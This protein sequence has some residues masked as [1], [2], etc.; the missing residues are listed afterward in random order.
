MRLFVVIPTTGRAEIVRRT[1]STLSGQSRSPD[2]ILVVA[3]SPADVSGL[4]ELSLPVE[5][6]FAPKGLCSQRNKA[7]ELL[8]QTADLIVFF[9]DDFIPAAS[10]LEEAQRLFEEI[11]ELVGA[12]GRMIADGANGPGISFEHGQELIA[13][14]EKGG[15][16]MESPHPMSAL[17]G[18]NMVFRCKSLDGLRFDEALPLYGWQED[19]DFTFRLGKRGRL[20]GSRVLAGVHMGA[21]VARSPGKRL[22]YS[23]IAN[24]VYLLK[25]GTTP[26]KLALKLMVQN[27]VANLIRSFSPEPHVDRRGRLHGNLLAFRD[28]LMGKL[29]PRR[30]LEFQ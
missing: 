7:L 20:V 4:E 15:R 24:P 1:I 28:L 30:I 11:P 17:Y 23:Q 16:S 25:K 21:K 14:D 12:C 18:C 8:R 13:Q 22:G 3:V 5:V 2:G 9:D 27:T 29:D 10:Y 6:T 19:I 26:K